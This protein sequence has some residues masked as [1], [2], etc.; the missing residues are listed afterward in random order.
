MVLELADDGDGD[1]MML[2]M[3]VI[4]NFPGDCTS[5]SPLISWNGT[6]SCSDDPD[7]GDDGDGGDGCDSPKN[8]LF[9]WSVIDGMGATPFGIR[10]DDDLY[11]IGYDGDGDDDGCCLVLKRISGASSS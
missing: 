10:D 4:P 3:M 9:S 6:P 2:V 1:G 5:I 11:C 7:D 8:A